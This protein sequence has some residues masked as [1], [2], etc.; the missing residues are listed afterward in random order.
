MNPDCVDLHAGLPEEGAQIGLYALMAG[1]SEFCWCAGWMSGLEFDLWDAVEKGGKPYGQECVTERQARLLRD[2]ADECDG[3]WVRT[4]DHEPAFIHL[5]EWRQR[6][7]T[8]R[9]GGGRA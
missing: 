2:L 3:W 4:V 8:L 6:L 5:D 7:A 1:I 9:A